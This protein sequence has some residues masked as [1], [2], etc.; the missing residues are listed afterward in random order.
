[1]KVR[2]IA[3]GAAVVL[4]LLAGGLL[5]SRKSHPK[6]TVSNSPDQISELDQR[7]LQIKAWSSALTKDT[8]SAIILGQLAGLYQQRARETGDDA[9]YLRSEEFARRS[10]VSRINRNAKSYVILASALLAQHR[11][12]EAEDAAA[13]AAAYDPE[14]TQYQALLGETRLELGDYDGARAAFAKVYAARRNLS[15]A[16]RLARWEELNGRPEIARSILRDAL[17]IAVMEHGLPREQVAWFYLRAGDLDLRYGRFRSARKYLAKGLERDSG[18]YRLLSAMSRLEYLDGNPEQAIRYGDAAIAAKLDPAT[19]GIMSDAYLQVGNASQAADYVKTME[20]A[21]S[22]QPG[23]YH[24]AWSLFL[25]DHNLRVNEVYR[26]ASEE[27]RGR[28]D[29]YGYDLVAWSLLKAG[30]PAEAEAMMRG[31]LRLGTIDPLLL[32]HAGMIAAANGKQTEARKY[33]TSALELNAS[34]DPVQAK[35]A[36]LTLDKLRT[37]TARRS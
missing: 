19:L 21:V 33:L 17:Q 13:K 3:I 2:S 31:A 16:P 5:G 12:K 25:L 23:A 36:R 11:F 8:A 20:V 15:I 32:Y 10:L 28:K 14:I 35:I 24:R 34:F 29:I 22:G 9:D 27:L 1:M 37:D 7:N 6:K 4:A 30:K 26:N 18:D